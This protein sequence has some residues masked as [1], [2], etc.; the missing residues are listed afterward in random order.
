MA[1]AFGSALTSQASVSRILYT[2]GRDGVLPRRFFGRL[3]ARYGTPVLAI[4]L[5]SV[6]SLLASKVSLAL[7]ASMISFGALVAFSVVNLAVIGHYLLERESKV[8][9]QGA[10][11][12]APAAVP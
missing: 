6:V 9:G 1:G 10:P 12:Q 11:A 8:G 5:V 4:A 7:L 2:M 3:S